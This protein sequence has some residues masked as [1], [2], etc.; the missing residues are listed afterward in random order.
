MKF[1]DTG[2]LVFLKIIDMLE[3]KEVQTDDQYMLRQVYAYHPVNKR[4]CAI[5]ERIRHLS[6]KVCCEP[7]CRRPVVV[8]YDHCGGR[9]RCIHREFQVSSEVAAAGHEADFVVFDPVEQYSN[10][11][12]PSVFESD[13]NP[14]LMDLFTSSGQFADLTGFKRCQEAEDSQV[15]LKSIRSGAYGSVGGKRV[16]GG[17]GHV[18]NSITGTALVGGACLRFGPGTTAS[19]VIF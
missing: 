9:G 19:A 6:E 5:R 13:L 11:Q 14:S 3:G 4:I 8:P 17:R 16:S 10:N 18:L 12:F 1:F 15:P 7:G 2:R